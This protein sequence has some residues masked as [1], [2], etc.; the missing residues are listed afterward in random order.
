[1]SAITYNPT[2]PTIASNAG[3]ISG[4]IT[5]S[6]F[7]TAIN[8]IMGSV[9]DKAQATQSYFEQAMAYNNGWISGGSV[10]T[11][12]GLSVNVAAYV[13]MCGNIIGDNA[14]QSVGGFSSSSTANMYL[15][16]D[17]TWTIGTA[18]PDTSDNHGTAILW[19]RVVTGSGTVTSIDPTNR[20]RFTPTQN[21]F[22]PTTLSASGTVTPPGKVLANFTSGTVYIPSAGSVTGPVSIKKISASGTV[23][24]APLAGSVEGAT[25]YNLT[26]QY[27]GV[28]LISDD[29]NWWIESK[30]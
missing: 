23:T 30:V 12:S 5:A 1:M 7:R 8:N 19:A 20:P 17:Q 6:D 26:A 29:L 11:G 25:T 9:E 15:R 21:L 3:T 28:M 2:N 4:P 27:A 24:I 16:Q 14:S 10:T 22:K 18:I 13:A